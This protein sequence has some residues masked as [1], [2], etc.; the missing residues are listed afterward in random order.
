MERLFTEMEPRILLVDDDLD[1]RELFL[2]AMHL[3][4][5]D[6][7]VGALENSEMLVGKLTQMSTLPEFLFLD[8]N[9]PKK[10][11]LQCLKEIQQHEKLKHIRVIIYS[12][13]LN[14][15]DIEETHADGAYCFVQKPNT[16]ADL[17]VILQNVLDRKEISYQ[18]EDYV[19]NGSWNRSIS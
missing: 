1:D 8:L 17:K 9:M 3:I 19:I 6:S 11:G 7:T 18:L 13:S 12:T 14:P 2:E 4:S 10:S 15:K 16:F 5:S